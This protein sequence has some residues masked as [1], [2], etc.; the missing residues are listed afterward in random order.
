MEDYPCSPVR[1]SERIVDFD[2]LKMF[3]FYKEKDFLNQSIISFNENKNNNECSFLNKTGPFFKPN[4][5]ILSTHQFIEEEPIEKSIFN[6]NV[7]PEKEKVSL[8]ENQQKLIY[9]IFQHD[10]EEIKKKFSG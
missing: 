2:S 3:S 9:Y 8:D 10:L 7:P 4:F 6:Q 5:K 1:D